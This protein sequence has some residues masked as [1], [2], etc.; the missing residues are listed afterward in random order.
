MERLQQFGLKLMELRR[1]HDKQ[2][3]EVKKIKGLM[4]RVENAMLAMLKEAGIKSVQVEDPAHDAKYTFAQG[5]GT[6]YNVSDMESYL[7]YVREHEDFS[8]ITSA[9]RKEAVVEYR[10]MNENQL[11]PGVKE[12]TYDDLSVR[13]TRVPAKEDA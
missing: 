6:R 2:A 13:T 7:A 3:D 8:M 5:G 10:R 12:T 4:E 11:P 1:I 9:V